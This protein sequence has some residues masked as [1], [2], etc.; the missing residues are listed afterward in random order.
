MELNHETYRHH[1]AA[2]NLSQEHEN[3]IM[4]TVWNIMA[5]HVDQAFGMHPAQLSRGKAPEIS[6][7][8]P[9]YSLRMDNNSKPYTQGG[10]RYDA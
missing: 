1:L 8:S 4:D 7:Q 5:S 3:D 2:L 10:I 6:L 9:D